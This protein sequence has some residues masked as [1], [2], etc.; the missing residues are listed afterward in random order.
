LGALRL[1]DAIIVAVRRSTAMK[2]SNRA[3]ATWS[4]GSHDVAPVAAWMSSAPTAIPGQPH[5]LTTQL[6][7]LSAR[8][9]KL[10]T[11]MVRLIKGIAQPPRALRPMDMRAVS[12]RRSRRDDRRCRC[13]VSRSSPDCTGS[14]GL[15]L[16][17]EPTRPQTT[18]SVTRNAAAQRWRLL[19]SLLGLSVLMARC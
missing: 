8:L 1:A 9:M 14:P 10:G 6:K 19:P 7:R 4:F 2:A 18:I 12:V 5:I 13:S 11:G 17:Q 15:E 3:T 16:G